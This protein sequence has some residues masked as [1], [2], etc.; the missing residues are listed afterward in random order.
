MKDNEDT[1]DMAEVDS[2]ALL[3]NG[4]L[5]DLE[6]L[7]QGFW[8]ACLDAVKMQ[9]QINYNAFSSYY[10]QADKMC[11]ALGGESCSPPQWMNVNDLARR[12]SE[13]WQIINVLNMSE[14]DRGESYPKAMQWLKDNEGHKPKNLG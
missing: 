7:R 12:L 14:L 10:K 2:N 6:E 11:V 8:V 1:Q 4:D 3:A 5:Q 13:A 9:D